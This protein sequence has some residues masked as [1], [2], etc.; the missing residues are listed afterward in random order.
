MQDSRFWRIIAVVMCGALI[1]VGHGLH[2]PGGESVPS[3]SS[4]AHAGGVAVAPSWNQIFTASQDGRT[5]YSWGR[6]EKSANYLGSATVPE[7]K[8]TPVRK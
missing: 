5:I 4:V 1:Y 3:F 2:N 6:W 8:A 7:E